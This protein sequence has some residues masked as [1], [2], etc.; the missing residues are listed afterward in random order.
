[1]TTARYAA[2]SAVVNGKLYVIGGGGQSGKG[3]EMYTP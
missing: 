3:H 2:G 1:M